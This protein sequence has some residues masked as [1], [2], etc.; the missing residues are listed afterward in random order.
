MLSTN[1]KRIAIIA[2]IALTVTF[3]VNFPHFLNSISEQRPPMP[4]MP[5]G[6]NPGARKGP[7]LHGSDFIC[8]QMIWYFVYSFAL[9]LI[10]TWETGFPLKPYPKRRFLHIVILIILLTAVFYTRENLIIRQLMDTHFMAMR[11]KFDAILMVRYLFVM[12][13]S[14]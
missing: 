14:P 11:K 9:L 3:V 13:L 2:L 5:F 10:T 4:P 7:P 12:V 8:F 6:G 1:K